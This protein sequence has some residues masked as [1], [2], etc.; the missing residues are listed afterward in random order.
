MTTTITSGFFLFFTT[1][2]FLIAACMYVSSKFSK[3]RMTNFSLCKTI[4][5]IILNF[6]C[7]KRGMIFQKKFVQRARN[8]SSAMACASVLFFLSP[9]LF[10]F[11]LL[12]GSICAWTLR[13]RHRSQKGR[14]YPADVCVL[15]CTHCVK[16][17]AHRHVYCLPS[18]TATLKP[19][20]V[21]TE[22]DIHIRTHLP[23]MNANGP[24]DNIYLH[25]PISLTR[26]DY[27]ALN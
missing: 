9:F 21:P 4:C 2:A 24:L 10:S 7:S 17:R 23:A 18:T 1:N 20:L 3:Q 27:E 11:F 8:I 25:S 26:N 19:Y 15:S 14:W 5:I 6:G 22:G 12:H 16:L 13:H